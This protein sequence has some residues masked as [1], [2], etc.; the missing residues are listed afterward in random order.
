MGQAGLRPQGKPDPKSSR[1]QA[2]DDGNEDCADLIGQAGDRSLAALSSSHQLDNPGQGCPGSHGGGS[3][4]KAAIA[5]ESSPDHPIAGP[6][7]DW[8]RFAGQ[9]GLVDGRASFRD[10]PIDRDLFARS[11]PHQVPGQ[12]FGQCHIDFLGSPDQPGSLGRQAHQVVN[13]STGLALGPVLQPAPQKDEAHDNGGGVEIGDRI[14]PGAGKSRWPQGHEKAISEGRAGPHRYQ[15]V[16][17]DRAMPPGAQGGSIETPPGP[18]LDQGGR[19]QDQPVDGLDRKKILGG[20]HQGHDAQGH[21]DREAGRDRQTMLLLGPLGVRG[22]QPLSRDGAFFHSTRH[23][24]FQIIAGRLDRT[25]Q[26]E[27]AGLGRP[28]RDGGQLGHQVDGGTFHPRSFAQVPFDPVDTGGAGHPGDRQ[29]DL[30][31]RS[32]ITFVYF[33]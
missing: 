5:I 6:P 20:K 14:D 33:A 15:G 25:N 17:V 29:D 30:D 9:H 3:E 1:R 11:H 2:K 7:I 23:W 26:L 24:R 28:V 18:E 31:G 32:G 16:H 27:A 12:N 22:R 4:D 13:G 10:D 21:H 19:A 8:N